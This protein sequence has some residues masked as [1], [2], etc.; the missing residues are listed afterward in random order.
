MKYEYKLNC[1]YFYL[2]EGCN[3]ACRHCWIKPKFQNGE[4]VYPALDFDL[5]KS[6][7]AQAKPLGLDSVKL[8]GGEPLLHPKILA[9][10]RHIREND[11]FLTVETNGVLCTPEIVQELQQHKK[12]FISVSLDGVDATTHEW[13]RG[14]KGSFEAALTGI[15]NLVQGG[16]KPQIIMSIMPHNKNQ[17][18]ALVHLAEDLGA[19]SVKFNI[20]QPTAR[21]EQMHAAGETISLEELIN[22][23]AWVENTLTQT[24]KIPLIYSHP[25][26]FKP[27]HKMFAKDAHGCGMCNIFGIIGVLGNGSYALCGIGESVPEMVFGDAAK[28]KL[29]D[30]WQNTPLLQAIRKGL[31]E[32]LE[33]VCRECLVRCRC[34]GYCI[35]QNYYRSHNLWAN[36]WYCEE[37]KKLGLFPKTRLV[38]G[39]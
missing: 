35:A 38:G 15:R 32:K 2:T 1:I 11:L 31:P 34:L 8:T 17:M 19:G 10:L 27:L 33:G 16:Y 6:I 28:N 29:A 5:F 26:A 14:V 13:V 20:V 22:L 25:A 36:H 12:V 3:L 21:G 18:E 37:A 39:I 23:G 30:V 4:H 24:V 9:I 7:I